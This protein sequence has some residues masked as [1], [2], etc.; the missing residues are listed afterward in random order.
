LA[1]D[2][3]IKTGRAAPS[4]E[5]LATYTRA[6]AAF[7]LDAVDARARENGLTTGMTLADARAIRPGL[8]AIEA[9]PLA[10]GALLD[11]LA[12][13]CERWSPAIVLAPPDGVFL[14]IGAT[15]HLFG[16]ESALREDITRRIAAGGF[17]AR[18]A[19]AD[20]P[21][22]AWALARFA[23]GPVA[24]PGETGEHLAPLPIAALR[25]SPPAEALLNKLGLTH[26]GALIARPRAPFAARAGEDAQRLLDE[27]LGRAPPALVYR[28]PPPDLFALRRFLEPLFHAD[29][30]MIAA[31]DAAEEI[32]AGLDLR[33][34]GAR[35][36]ALNLFAVSGGRRR[37]E[38]GFSR[39]ETQVKALL[40]AFREQLNA[41]ED[42]RTFEFGVE[43]IRLD[44]LETG[45][46]R[47]DDG[48]AGDARLIDALSARLGAVNVRRLACADDHWPE[49]AAA[50][51]PALT[52]AP[53]AHRPPARP[54][55]LKLLARPEPIETLA[56]TPDGPPRRFRWR[57]VQHEVAR[58]EGPERI[59]P[60]WWEREALTRDYFHVEDAAGARFWIFREGLYARE[61]P[62]PAWFVHGFFG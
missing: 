32:V 3:L 33:G 52:D 35:R 50:S 51:A 45:R 29:A 12:A 11:R 49:R 13:F 23:R 9:D 40:R 28:R 41:A 27:A 55:P 39:P 56:A 61:T 30:L 34:V 38:A 36:L 47:E 21:G 59:A 31:A 4:D 10:D 14:E 7:V 43:A 62:T 48:D 24:P 54:R 20:T 46:L 53:A 57:R 37:L 6:G 44:V 25:L 16:G 19:L 2:R 26:I 42:D 8:V 18:V 5:G 15:A 1:T 58:A 60:D 22:A 17:S